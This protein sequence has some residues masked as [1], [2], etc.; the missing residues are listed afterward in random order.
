MKEVGTEL[1]PD[2]TSQ[3]TTSKNLKN[4]VGNGAVKATLVSPQTWGA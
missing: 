3:V 4:N 2:F 1:A